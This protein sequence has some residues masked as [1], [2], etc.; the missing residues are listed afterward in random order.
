MQLFC[1]IFTSIYLLNRYRCLIISYIF[2]IVKHIL[3]FYVNVGSHVFVFS[4]KKMVTKT[5]YGNRAEKI[6]K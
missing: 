1:D 2:N 5:A 3:D 6:K 4:V